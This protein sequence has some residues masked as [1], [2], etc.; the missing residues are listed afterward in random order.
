[1]IKIGIHE[2]LDRHVDDTS[3][4]TSNLPNES[5]L[6]SAVVAHNDFVRLSGGHH[7]A[8]SPLLGV[9]AFNE[10]RRERGFSVQE[11]SA[12]F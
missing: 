11:G 3:V 6:A 12:H 5:G 9:L 10:I 7:N 8:Q 2:F 1:M 4:L